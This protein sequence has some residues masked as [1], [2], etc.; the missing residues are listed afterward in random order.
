MAIFLEKV[1]KDTVTY[2]T[3]GKRTTVKPIDVVNALKRQGR[4]IYGYG[5]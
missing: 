1:L 4:A 2:V 5:S 3:H